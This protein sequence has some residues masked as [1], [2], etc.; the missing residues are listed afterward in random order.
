MSYTNRL[1]QCG[2][3]IPDPTRGAIIAAAFGEGIAR[4]DPRIDDAIAGIRVAA[5]VPRVVEVPSTATQEDVLDA[6]NTFAEWARRNK[7]RLGAM[8]SGIGEGAFA[9][10]IMVRLP[11]D[12]EE[13]A[14]DASIAIAQQHGVYTRIKTAPDRWALVYFT[15]DA[16][17]TAVTAPN[18]DPLSQRPTS[19]VGAIHDLAAHGASTAQWAVN[20]HG[21]VDHAAFLDDL[22]RA[23]ARRAG[24]RVGEIPRVGTTLTP[25]SGA[26]RNG[27]GNVKQSEFKR[28]LKEIRQSIKALE[29]AD[30][31][32]Q[33][34]LSTLS[35]NVD[36]LREKAVNPNAIA[37]LEKQ[38]Q[39]LTQ[40]LQQVQDL[41][42]QYQ[43]LGAELQA[44]RAQI[45]ALQAAIDRRAEAPLDDVEADEEQPETRRERR[46]RRRRERSMGEDW[47]AEAREPEAEDA[48]EA[49]PDEYATEAVDAVEQF[50]DSGVG[51]P[52]DPTA[53]NVDLL[54][55][56]FEARRAGGGGGG[57]GAVARLVSVN[58]V[59]VGAIADALR[60]RVAGPGPGMLN[61]GGTSM[62]PGGGGGMVPSGGN[63]GPGWGPGV[64]GAGQWGYPRG[65][66]GYAG[67]D[68]FLQQQLAMLMF[69][70]LA[71][72]RQRE[73]E[74]DAGYIVTL[75]DEDDEDADVQGLGPAKITP[76][77]DIDTE[78]RGAGRRWREV[79]APA[80]LDPDAEEHFVEMVDDEDPDF[81]VLDFG[82]TVESAWPI[83][84]PIDV[85]RPPALNSHMRWI[86]YPG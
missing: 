25:S 36:R 27:G 57:G 83:G 22:A 24:T 43:A 50:L 18:L 47:Q 67:P 61:G 39:D 8:W 68:P 4:P 48:E 78:Y 85:P 55:E 42:A 34:R 54:R 5:A 62:V 17:A 1:R 73:R 71:A 2:I 12:A 9:H 38:V 70:N 19:S 79:T 35:G 6:T 76:V 66:Y 86:E 64:P 44:Q 65:Q 80:P 53:P 45:E 10:G 26:P 46:E 31:V 74:R 72:A 69:M 82:E 77:F 23:R 11:R 49:A 52:A 14:A 51:L 58:G 56:A 16:A 28:K 40:Q 59:Y 7:L 29:S 75:Y 81:Y 63:S 37:T 84:N 13:R 20:E 3:S 41:G 32:T 21:F 33:K 60:P 30:R 15:T